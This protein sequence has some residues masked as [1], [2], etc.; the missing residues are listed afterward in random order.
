M[1]RIFFAALGVLLL[2]LTPIQAAA[3]LLVAKVDVSTQTMTVLYNGEVAYRWPV[4]TARAGKYTPRGTWSAKWLSKY[5]KSSLYNNAPMPFAIFFN[6][7]YAIHG[8]DQ[9]SRLG[10]PASA[11][12]VRLHPDH[13]AR[14]FELT[15]QV[16]KQ[17]MRVVIQN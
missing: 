2:S 17:N 16:G 3:S 14:L 1:N 6:G 12:C 10:R 15:Q 13:A 4:S 8:T 9:V 11:G 7:N 5:H